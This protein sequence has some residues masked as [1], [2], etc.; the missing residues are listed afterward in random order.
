MVAVTLIDRA[1]RG[2]EKSRAGGV[3]HDDSELRTGET[4]RWIVRNN[5]LV[6]C[7]V[8]LSFS[9]GQWVLRC[10]YCWLCYRLLVLLFSARAAC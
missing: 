8:T 3:G 9:V 7:I 10:G 5:S 6:L 2:Q 1:V 4:D